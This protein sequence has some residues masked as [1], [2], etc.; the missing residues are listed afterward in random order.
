MTWRL[1]KHGGGA[2]EQPEN[3]RNFAR[4]EAAESSRLFKRFK[5][6]LEW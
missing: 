5:T 6:W 3:G 1:Q 4:W 2:A